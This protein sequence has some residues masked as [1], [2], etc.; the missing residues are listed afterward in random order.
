MILSVTSAAF[1]AVKYDRITRYTEVAEHNFEQTNNIFDSWY[2]RPHNRNYFDRKLVIT[3]F[4]L[5]FQ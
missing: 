3:F 5:K 2:Y 4:S 1:V